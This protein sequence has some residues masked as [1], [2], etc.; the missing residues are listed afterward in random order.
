MRYFHWQKTS[1]VP[2]RLLGLLLI[3]AIIVRSSENIYAGAHTKIASWIHRLLILSASLLL[4]VLLNLI[5]LSCLAA[6]LIV[7]GD[8]LTSASLYTD[9]YECGYSQFVSFVFMVLFN[10]GVR[11]I[12]RKILGFLADDVFV[13]KIIF[14]QPSSLSDMKVVIIYAGANIF[15]FGT[16][17]RCVNSSAAFRTMRIF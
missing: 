7:R 4:S 11:H 6:I 14:R 15:P 8:K 2:E 16:M 13:V 3:S 17:S 10:S 12:E 9:G 1:G 5:P